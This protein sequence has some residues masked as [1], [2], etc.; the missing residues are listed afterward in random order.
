[1]SGGARSGPELSGIDEESDRTILKMTGLRL[2]DPEVEEKARRRRFTAAYK[3]KIV[4]EAD[5]CTERGQLGALLRREGLYYSNLQ[6]WRK[7]RERGEYDALSEKKRGRK[8]KAKNPLS[9]ENIQLKHEIER[10]KV[11][12]KKARIIIDVQKKISDL[13]GIE[14]PPID[15]DEMD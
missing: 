11:E 12:L 6:T 3:L 14:Q 5:R 9:K 8:A 10:L 2:P 1:V 15:L 13:L 7:A 4:R